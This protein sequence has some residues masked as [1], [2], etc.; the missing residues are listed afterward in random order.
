MITSFD[1]K[2]KV[3]YLGQEHHI[4]SES[5]HLNTLILVFFHSSRDNKVHCKDCH[6]LPHCALLIIHGL[7]SERITTWDIQN[8]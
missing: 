5:T 6:Q 1:I 3:A 4:L 8:G 7:K 2:A